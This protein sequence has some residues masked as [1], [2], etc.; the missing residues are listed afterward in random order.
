MNHFLDCCIFSQTI[1]V[2]LIVMLHWLLDEKWKPYCWYVWFCKFKVKKLSSTK[3]RTK[4]DPSIRL[5]VGQ[6][7]PM[8]CFDLWSKLTVFNFVD[9]RVT[10]KLLGLFNL[11][12]SRNHNEFFSFDGWFHNLNNQ[13]W[14][15]R[16]RIFERMIFEFCTLFQTRLWFDCFLRSFRSMIPGQTYFSSANL[17][18]RATTLACR[19]VARIFSLF[20]LV[21]LCWM[22]FSILVIWDVRQVT[23]RFAFHWSIWV[24]TE[25]RWNTFHL[26]SIRS[27]IWTNRNTA[28]MFGIQSTIHWRRW[29]TGV[30]GSMERRSMEIASFVSTRFDLMTMGS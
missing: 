3:S 26:W 15:S 29:T 28:N 9:Q 2:W 4:K 7:S 19:S 14:G 8:V 11:N 23:T 18:S 6:R 10:D 27:C 12:H 24:N 21:C 20:T 5:T 30:C 22:K 1:I 13:N 16:G 25:K 17:F